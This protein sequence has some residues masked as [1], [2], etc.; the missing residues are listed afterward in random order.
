VFISSGASLTNL[1]ILL[2]VPVSADLYESV[3]KTL[4]PHFETLDIAVFE[5]FIQMAD[6][7]DDFPATEIAPA[8]VKTYINC[9]SE[10]RT[11][12]F[13]P[14]RL[15]RSIMGRHLNL[16]TEILTAIDHTIPPIAEWNYQPEDSFKSLRVGLANL[17]ATCY[18]NA[19][20]Q[21]LFHIPQCRDFI[22]HTSFED[23]GLQELQNVFLNLQY[24]VRRSADMSRFTAK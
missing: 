8:M 14:F 6:H 5:I 10:F 4:F 13:A 20:L 15:L 1:P 12:P 24:S 9:H 3:F 19:V 16:R 17:G 7:W 23:D 22:L 21:Q 11:V 2:T 18:V